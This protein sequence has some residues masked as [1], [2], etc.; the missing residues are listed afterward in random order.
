MMKLML[1]NEFTE[2]RQHLRRRHTYNNKKKKTFSNQSQPI[3]NNKTVEKTYIP[4][5]DIAHTRALTYNYIHQAL[6]NMIG[7]YV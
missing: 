7:F 1:L 2:S 5:V 4:T 6:T 3:N